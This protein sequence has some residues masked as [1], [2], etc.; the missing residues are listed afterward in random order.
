M[1]FVANVFKFI[2]I[3]LRI[4]VN[5]NLNLIKNLEYKTKKN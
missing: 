4:F 3:Q 2:S 5:F 1:K